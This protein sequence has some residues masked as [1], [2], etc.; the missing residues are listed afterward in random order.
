MQKIY[1]INGAARSGKTTFGKLVDAELRQYGIS[2]LHTSS[3]NPV[4]Q[5][6]C[7]YETWPENLK[8]AGSGVLSVLKREVTELDWSGR[9][10]D[11]DDYWRKAMSDLKEKINNW[12][13]FL[14]HNLVMDEFS[15]LG[16][17]F[18]GFVDI[19]E[20][21]NII[22]FKE[23]VVTTYRFADTVET[24]RVTSDGAQAYNNNSDA[25]VGEIK[26]DIEIDNP[27]ESFINGEVSLWLLKCRAK[28]FV[29]QEILNGR[30]KERFY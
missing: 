24:V 10:E 27:R 4:K 29:E 11:K 1:I 2:F 3:I 14:I 12:N 18:V 22:S 30:T 16:P 25:R 9:E 6:L 13:P 20:P 21:E 23:H 5:I 8:K 26:Y 15:K 7:A 28:T 19:R 17:S